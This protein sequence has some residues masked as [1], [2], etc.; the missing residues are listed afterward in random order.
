MRARLTQSDS[1]LRQ[2][3]IGEVRSME[4]T[5]QPDGQRKT[6]FTRRELMGA[7]SM[8]TVGAAM[9]PG[10]F[11]AAQSTTG[12][13]PRHSGEHFAPLENFKFDLEG[14]S[15][16]VGAGGSAKE[17]TVEQ[18]PISESIAGVSMRLQPGGL[19]ELHWHAIAAEWAY[20][21]EGK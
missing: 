8:A 10:P 5:Q 3:E 12:G 15:G 6:K 16:W 9:L 20:V 11:A 1:S 2:D 13:P 19:R 17:V 14:S 18:F 4:K 7:A 21:V